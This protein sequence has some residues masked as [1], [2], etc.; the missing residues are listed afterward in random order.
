ML[1][2]GLLTLVVSVRAR[3]TYS[4]G[5]LVGVRVRLSTHLGASYKLYAAPSREA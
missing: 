1:G 3:V 4:S 5:Y 2:L